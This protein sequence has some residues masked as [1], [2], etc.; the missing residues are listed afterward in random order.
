MNG[1]QGLLGRRLTVRLTQ[2]EGADASNFFRVNQ[3]LSSHDYLVFLIKASPVPRIASANSWINRYWEKKHMN[4]HSE[5]LGYLLKIKS[6]KGRMLFC[7]VT[8]H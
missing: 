4:G 8:G 3:T 5:K 1:A 6:W 7:D 2:L